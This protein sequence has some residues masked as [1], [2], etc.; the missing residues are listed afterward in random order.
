[1]TT[2]DFN[3]LFEVRVLHDYYLSGTQDSGQGS[4]TQSFFAMD[5]ATQANRVQELLRS[6][7]YDVRNE[8]A[9]IPGQ[10]EQQLFNDLR[11]RLLNTATGFC[12]AMEV[13]KIS[14]D[15]SRPVIALDANTSLAFAISYS[16][17]AF[18]AISNVT[19]RQP[20]NNA[21][22]IYFFT[23]DTNQDAALSVQVGAW[24]P[25]QAYQMGDLAQRTSGTLSQATQDNTGDNSDKSWMVIAGKGLVHQADR[26]LS[27]N[28][29]VLASRYQS[30]SLEEL[31]QSSEF[32]SLSDDEKWFVN[33]LPTLPQLASPLAGVIRITLQN[34]NGI[35]SPLDADGLLQPIYPVFELRFLSRITYWRYRKTGKFTTDEINAI[36]K[37][38]SGFLVQAGDDFVTKAARPLAREL[39]PLLPPNSALAIPN[40]QPG[41]IQ[42]NDKEGKVYSNIYFNDVISKAAHP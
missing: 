27:R 42:A 34:G 40:P 2:T 41:N 21:P 3:I 33:W 32:Q 10:N 8:L 18:G 19:L 25:E 24:T 22:D 31:T 9:F 38:A 29:E 4:K 20:G 35:W 39:P 7:R 23:N 5:A 12:V 14:Q 37:D 11:L 17:L 13:E 28:L 30:M 1:M 36:N 26:R 6:G 16:N 15:K